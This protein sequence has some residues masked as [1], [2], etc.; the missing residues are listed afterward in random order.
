MTAGISAPGAG[1][2][3][4]RPA[5]RD[6]SKP[7][8]VPKDPDA[9]RQR[10]AVL[11]AALLSGFRLDLEKRL[12]RTPDSNEFDKGF[13]I[14]NNQAVELIGIELRHKL[15]ALRDAGLLPSEDRE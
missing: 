6:T 15:Q 11:E 8:W 9:L 4:S 2:R 14:G 1:L 10:V 5:A 3:A 12:D 13:N 7:Y